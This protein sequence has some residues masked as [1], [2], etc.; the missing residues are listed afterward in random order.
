MELSDKELVGIITPENLPEDVLVSLDLSQV[1]SLAIFL[2]KQLVIQRDFT[3]NEPMI[4]VKDNSKIYSEKERSELAKFLKSIGG[5]PHLN[6]W[7]NPGY[8]DSQKK[9]LDCG[10]ENI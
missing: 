4:L 5:C 1:K 6:K 7:H 3:R 8:A 2:F 9:C 10:E